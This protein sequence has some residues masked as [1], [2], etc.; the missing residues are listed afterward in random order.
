MDEHYYCGICK[1]IYIVTEECVCLPDKCISKCGE[2]YFDK[3]NF[4]RRTQEKKKMTQDVR[5]YKNCLIGVIC[6]SFFLIC[7]TILL[8]V[9]SS[10]TYSVNLVHSQGT[11]SDAIDD[12]DTNTPDVKP[13]LN[14]TGLPLQ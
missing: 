6:L 11:S 3:E 2:C 14:L 1:E 13:N 12:T 9:L 7:V 8:F 5:G 10:C 4:K